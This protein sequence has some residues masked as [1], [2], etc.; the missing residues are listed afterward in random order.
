LLRVFARW[1]DRGDIEIEPVEA[2]SAVDRTLATGHPDMNVALWQAAGYDRP[3]STGEM[4]REVSR[5]D[6]VVGALA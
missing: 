3:P 4:I 1:Y 2:E 5:Y 6:C